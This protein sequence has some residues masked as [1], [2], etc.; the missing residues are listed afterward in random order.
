MLTVAFTIAEEPAPT[1]TPLAPTTGDMRVPS[2]TR[3]AFAVLGLVL[4]PGRPRSSDDQERH[5]LAAL[6]VVSWPTVLR[7][8]ERGGGHVLLSPNPPKD[9]DGRREESGRGG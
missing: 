3:L 2:G 7:V 8:R 5:P 4:A 9:T 1:P 6:P